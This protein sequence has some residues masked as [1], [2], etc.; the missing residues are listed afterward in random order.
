MKNYV[1]IKC[2]P[3]NDMSRDQM[4]Q[5]QKTLNQ[6]KDDQRI[7]DYSR[8]FIHYS[9]NLNSSKAINNKGINSQAKKQNKAG[10]DILSII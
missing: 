7:F 2:F 5:S 6:S 1:T 4:N 9:L 3:S 8:Y 10:R